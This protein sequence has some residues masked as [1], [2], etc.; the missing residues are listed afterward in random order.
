MLTMTQ[1]LVHINQTIIIQGRVVPLEFK[2]LPNLSGG[3][4][5]RLAF[6]PDDSEPFSINTLTDWL[7]VSSDYTSDLPDFLSEVIQS[8]ALQ[9]FTLAWF[10]AS[11]PTVSSSSNSRPP[12]FSPIPSVVEID[13]DINSLK[14]IP[15]VLEIN[16]L[17]LSLSIDQ[18]LDSLRRTVFV[19]A[20]GVIEI[21]DSLVRAQMTMGRNPFMVGDGPSS[22]GAS[23]GQSLTIELD[24]RTRPL[25]LGGVL[26]VFLPGVEV[27]PSPLDSLAEDV[28]LN[29]LM[30]SIE[31]TDAKGWTIAQL[32]VQ[33]SLE[34]VDLDIFGEAV[35]LLY[36]DH[37]ISSYKCWLTMISSS[38]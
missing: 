37:L 26:D 31:K 38:F 2:A 23:A 34:N 14:V 35:P 5:Y 11:K 16:D 32:L 24:C 19:D 18:P 25:K 30:L 4:E 21:G 3:M 27:L 7:Q 28:K 29:R 13:A 8:I 1:I 20:R 33:L 10:G 9:S 12:S 22:V 17:S 36:F 6:I 15:D